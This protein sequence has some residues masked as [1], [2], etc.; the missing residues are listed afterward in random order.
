MGAIAS[1]AGWPSAFL[2]IY[3]LFVNCT[4]YL[5]TL[6]FNCVILYTQPNRRTRRHTS[7]RRQEQ[8]HRGS[9]MEKMCP[10]CRQTLAASEFNKHRRSKD[11]LGCYCRKCI[12]DYERE[13]K[14]KK[15]SPQRYATMKR[16]DGYSLEYKRQYAAKHPERMRAIDAVR[17]AIEAGRISPVR[18]Q[19]CSVCGTQ[20]Q[21][22]HH[23]DYAKKLEVIP[24]CKSCHGKLHRA[25]PK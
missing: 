18:T 13:R 9:T 1:F 25:L 23:A 14:E 6:Q 22:Y 19:K 11:G 3:N 21:D 2:S 24:L 17:R 4:I 10:R 8:S 5:L 20:A 15:P 7:R 12:N 16:R